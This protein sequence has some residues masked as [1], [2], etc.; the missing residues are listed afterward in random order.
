MP[1]EHAHCRK[2]FG[3]DTLKQNLMAFRT[4]NIFLVK[5]CKKNRVLQK[6]E[7]S[8][9]WIHVKDEEVGCIQKNS[10][11]RSR[12]FH[13]ITFYTSGRN[14]SSNRHFM[15]GSLKTSQ[16]KKRKRKEHTVAYIRFCLHLDSVPLCLSDPDLP[17]CRINYEAAVTESCSRI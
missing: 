14:G 16:G 4:P 7:S 6:T 10:K 13:M 8:N 5:L 1:C 9:L 17:L 11:T 3:T 2:I 12:C 15:Q